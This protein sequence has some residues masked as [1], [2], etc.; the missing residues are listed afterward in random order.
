MTHKLDIA[1]VRTDSLFF[2]IGGLK[3]LVMF[4]S[5]LYNLPTLSLHEVILVDYLPKVST[6]L[7]L[8]CEHKN[9]WCECILYMKEENWAVAAQAVGG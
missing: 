1:I 8:H 4:C 2:W 6:F 9:E 5:L 3:L 7:S